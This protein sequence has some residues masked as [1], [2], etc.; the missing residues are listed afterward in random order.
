MVP[1][2]PQDSVEQLLLAAC[3]VRSGPAP[4]LLIRHSSR[5]SL[6]E[7]SMAAAFEAPL[8]DAG[9]EQAR[10]FAA[11]LP[12]EGAV[13]LHHS[14]VPRCE[15]TAR[16]IEQQIRHAGGRAVLVGPRED[17]GA[18]FLLDPQRAIDQFAELGMGGFVEA[19]VAD[20][21]SDAIVMPYRQAAAALLRALLDERDTD[22]TEALQLHVGHDLTVV[23]LLGLAYAVDRADFAWPGFLDGCVI[24]GR[25]E[26]L[27]CHYHGEARPLLDPTDGPPHRTKDDHSTDRS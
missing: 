1:S 20:R 10:L 21:V 15:E 22:P 24:G 23:T 12:R 11:R 18:P 13:R 2:T 9:R 14:P 7:A 26:Q 25:R 27:V 17:L 19:W 8:T 6:R 16:L 3:P 5:E 4:I